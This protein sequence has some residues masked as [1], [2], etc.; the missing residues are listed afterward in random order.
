MTGMSAD[1]D[2]DLEP[3]ESCGLRAAVGVWKDLGKWELPGRR[4]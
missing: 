3:E 4:V 1:V 2:L